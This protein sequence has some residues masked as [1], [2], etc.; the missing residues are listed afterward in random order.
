MNA[1]TIINVVMVVI[2]V[3]AISWFLTWTAISISAVY[4]T[5]SHRAC[6]YRIDGELGSAARVS[7][8]LCGGDAEAAE[9]I[10]ALLD[11]GFEP[12]AVESGSQYFRRDNRR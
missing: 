9:A 1:R 6:V 3:I 8:H 11:E 4:E 2:G 5:P 12:Y 7:V 10:R